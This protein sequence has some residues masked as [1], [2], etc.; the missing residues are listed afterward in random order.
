M[1]SLQIDA[2]RCENKRYRWIYLISN[3]W[4]ASWFLRSATTYGVPAIS[5]KTKHIFLLHISWKHHLI[6]PMP[7]A[8]LR[9]LQYIRIMEAS[10]RSGKWHIQVV[11]IMGHMNSCVRGLCKWRKARLN[12]LQAF[13]KCSSNSPVEV[14]NIPATIQIEEWASCVNKT[15]LLH[16]VAWDLIQLYCK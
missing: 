1:I 11:K 9:L 3:G 8:I 4:I 2:I 12:Y 13:R 5:L 15:E 6:Q 7:M 10:R 16:G 14:E